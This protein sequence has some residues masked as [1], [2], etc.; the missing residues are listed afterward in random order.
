MA[1]YA[2]NPIQSDNQLTMTYLQF[3]IL[4]HT[5]H[6]HTAGV[7][8]V[9]LSPNGN[10]LLSAGKL[11][12][13]LIYSI[14]HCYPGDDADVV[15]WNTMT[16]EKMQVISSAFH[17]P[18]GALV[19]VSS[20]PDMSPGFAFGCADGSIHVYQ[21]LESSV[22]NDDHD[23]LTAIN[24]LANCF[25]SNYQYFVQE[26]VHDGPIMDIKFDPKF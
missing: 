10:R 26:L 8:A 12:Q 20:K 21:L 25:Q 4:N 6:H 17:G 7:N 11:S 23:L 24:S 22:R 19:W 2:Y 14:I 1:R 13:I 9:A 18:V 3:M 15:V 5:L 16:G